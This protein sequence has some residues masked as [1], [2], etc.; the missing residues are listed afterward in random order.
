[1][2]GILSISCSCVNLKMGVAP[3]FKY[4][5][6]L[7]ALPNVSALYKVYTPAD[8]LHLYY[9]NSFWQMQLLAINHF[10]TESTCWYS[11]RFALQAWYFCVGGI[12]SSLEKKNNV[13]LAAKLFPDIFVSTFS[14]IKHKKRTKTLGGKPL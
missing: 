5:V 10:K 2:K 8:G 1:M 3:I 13:L 12:G 14:S 7:H 4:T 6:N 9:L 11:L